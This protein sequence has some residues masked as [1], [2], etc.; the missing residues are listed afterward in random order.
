MTHDEAVAIYRGLIRCYGLHW[1][2]KVPDGAW[3]D[4]AKVNAILTEADRR[5]ALANLYHPRRRDP[6]APT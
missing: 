6:S 1:T 4:L 5:K 2:A 3:R